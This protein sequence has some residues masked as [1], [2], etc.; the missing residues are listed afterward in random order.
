MDSIQHTRIKLLN[1]KAVN[2]SGRYILYW[3]QASHRCEYNHALEYAIIKANEMHTP[4]IVLFTLTENFPRANERHY[5]FMLEGLREVESSL[6]NR[7][8]SLI[9]RQ[10]NP[11][12]IINEFA[13]NANLIVVDRGYLRIE[14]D[15]REKAAAS[16]ACPLIQVETN[17]IVPVE[18]ASNKEEYSAAT[19]RPK[20]FRK[21]HEYLIPL[22]ELKPRFSSLNMDFQSLDIDD[23]NLTLSKLNILRD[24][25]PVDSLKGG[26]GKAKHFLKSFIREKLDDYPNFR[27]DP[28]INCLSGMS[29]YLHF[30]QIS[31]LYIALEVIKSNSPGVDSYLEELVVRRE[32]SINFVYYN[33]NYDSIQALPDWAKKTLTIHERDLRPYIY[34]LEDLEKGRTH[35]Q[36]WNACQI[37]MV[38]TGKMH[39]YMRMYWCKKIIEWSETIEEAYNRAVY[40]ND[41]YEVD[42][43][44]PNSYA[45]IAWCFGK[46]DRPWPERPIFGKVRFM[47][48]ADRKKRLIFSKYIDKV[49][50]LR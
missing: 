5:Y 37:E 42:G 34:S 26:T 39:S 48:L 49:N 13:E 21:L 33:S 27:N 7:G 50:S 1:A 9:I 17:V 8:I 31:P 22:P 2:Y 20:I 43:R 12:S 16:V 19:F 35:D 6:K 24:V 47:G 14:R 30:G 46:H 44:D 38:K 36:L 45:G 11:P 18:E 15:W 3:M 23:I 4:L 10:G 29:P 25:K 32:L 28:S 41:K 40:L